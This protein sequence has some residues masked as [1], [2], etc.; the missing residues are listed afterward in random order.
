MVDLLCDRH[1][2]L[3]SELN[4]QIFLCLNPATRRKFILGL[5]WNFYA[6]FRHRLLTKVF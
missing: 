3:P 1:R 5:G 6:M 2:K 4:Q